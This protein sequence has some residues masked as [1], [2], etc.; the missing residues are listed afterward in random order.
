MFLTR[1]SLRTQTHKLIA[2]GGTNHRDA[3]VFDLRTDR[4]EQ[5]PLVPHRGTGRS[6]RRVLAHWTRYWSHQR[7]PTSLPLEIDAAQQE[8]LRALGY[9]D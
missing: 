6:L 3:W 5:K 2:G 9:L 7:R 1:T 4:G 8:Q